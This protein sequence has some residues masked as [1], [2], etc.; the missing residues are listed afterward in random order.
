[1]TRFS[2]HHK[3]YAVLY[4]KISGGSAGY[5]MDGS[6][7]EDTIAVKA[8]IQ[9]QLMPMKEEDFQALMRTLYNKPYAMVY[10]YDPRSGYRTM[11][12]MYEVGMAEYMDNL[13]GGNYWKMPPIV[14]TER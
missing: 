1:M 11:E 9:W 4:K 2:A 10:Y 12:A 13:V 8:Q 5:M 14:F 7:T 6:Y 3:D